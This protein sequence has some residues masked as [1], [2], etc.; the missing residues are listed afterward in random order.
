VPNPN[1]STNSSND[2]CL[3]KHHQHNKN[4]ALDSDSSVHGCAFSCGRL[5]QK[6]TLLNTRKL[7]DSPI[8]HMIEQLS[9]TSRLHLNQ[10]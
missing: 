10:N 5:P 7:N 8:S 4:S 1:L 9:Q 3:S 6:T 2:A